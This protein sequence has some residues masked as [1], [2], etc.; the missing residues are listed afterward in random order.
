M[1]LFSFILFNSNISFIFEKIFLHFKKL[2][3]EAVIEKTTRKEQELA[4]ENLPSIN[5]LVKSIG[6][7]T[8]TMAIQV[9]DS[10]Q[11]T[12][13]LPAKLFNVLQSILQLMSE[14]KAFSVIPSNA[15]LTTQEAADMLNVSRPYIVKLLEKG[16]IP[17]HKVGT[18]RRINLEDLL[19]YA[20]KMKKLRKEA[21]D[22]LSRLGQQYNM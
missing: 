14:G 18:H 11:M 15:E 17:S 3:M 22:E 12:L 7:G 2:I 6:K 19:A 20:A 4:K 8:D 5:R 13:N 21:L 1:N 10:M 9:N 16:E